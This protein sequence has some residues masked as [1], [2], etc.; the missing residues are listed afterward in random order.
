MRGVRIWTCVNSEVVFDEIAQ[1]TDEVRRKDVMLLANATRCG[2]L[3][4]EEVIARADA[5]EMMGFGAY[6]ALHLACAEKA[7]CGVLLTTDDRFLNMAARHSTRL[8]VRV[9][10][11]LS[12]WSE[13]VGST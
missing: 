3:V 9:A 6:D 2:R 1:T 11:P 4:D 12:W 7:R 5:L 10:N 8:R 13:E